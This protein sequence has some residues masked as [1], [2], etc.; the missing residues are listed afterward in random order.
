MEKEGP[1]P[2]IQRK[3]NDGWECECEG[4]DDWVVV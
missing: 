2:P 1:S 4:G 3:D